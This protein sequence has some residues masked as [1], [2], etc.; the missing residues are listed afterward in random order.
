MGAMEL[1]IF[2]S[3]LVVLGAAFV[4]LICDFLK[5]NNEKLREFNIE[6]ITRQEERERA[7][8]SA[9][10]SRRSGQPQAAR[11][12]EAGGFAEGAS[13]PASQVVSHAS[14]VAEGIPAN[15]RRRRAGRGADPV[16]AGSAPAGLATAAMPPPAPVTA[17]VAMEDW[18][19]R[20]VEHGASRKMEPALGPEFRT[21]AVEPV[22]VESASPVSQAGPRAAA[23]SESVLPVSA[24]L[25][26]IG[27]PNPIPVA[28]PASE[29]DINFVDADSG[30]GALLPDASVAAESSLPF[31][32]LQPLELAPLAEGT[33]PLG[34]EATFVA[35]ARDA[36]IGEPAG[37]VDQR[38]KD[39]SLP[40]AGLSELEMPIPSAVKL[41][42]GSMAPGNVNPEV[43]AASIEFQTVSQPGSAPLEPAL[44]V[45]GLSDLVI[46]S[47]AAVKS[48][49]GEVAPVVELEI[50]SAA[51]FAG[52]RYGQ[53]PGDELAPMEAA[54]QPISALLKPADSSRAQLIPA[55]SHLTPESG[56][57]SSSDSG[58]HRV[59][60]EE[61][62]P[63]AGNTE[64]SVAL[65]PLAKR[66]MALDATPEMGPVMMDPDAGP[67]GLKPQTGGSPRLAAMQLVPETTFAA[68]LV[69]AGREPDV[70]PVLPEIQDPAYNLASGSMPQPPDW[71]IEEE[72]PE[73]A[74]PNPEE[75]VR[76]RV[77]DESDLFQLCGLIQL[78]VSPVSPAAA[79]GLL[80][81]AGLPEWSC[82][83]DRD[84]EIVGS[85][86]MN[87]AVAEGS[88]PAVGVV[89]EPAPAAC[90][91]ARSR[92]RIPEPRV[93]ESAGISLPCFYPYV[94]ADL[95]IEA[96][97]CADTMPMEFTLDS[98]LEDAY[99]PP[100]PPLG[101]DIEPVEDG[102]Y[103]YI[104][105]DNEPEM[106]P[107]V[108]QMP[109]PVQAA[110]EPPARVALRIPR[111][112]HDRAAFD[113]LAS[114]PANF[115]GV[116]FLVG[117][118][119]F[120]HLVADHGQP[121]VAQAI[122]EATSYFGGLLKTDGFGCW[123]EDS[124]FVMI[125]PAA[126]AEQARQVMTHTAEGLW[127]YQLRSLGSLPLIFHWGSSEASGES[128]GAAVERARDQM[129]ESGR[130]RKKVLTT[131]GRF[132]RRVVNG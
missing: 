116:V 76:V 79:G 59:H 120:D 99:V 104:E 90:A 119:G 11:V 101:Y 14:T 39:P 46:S 27:S 35:V 28:V 74:E 8:A 117:V 29:I 50:A 98:D 6:L 25:V 13:R 33:A 21:A 95:E 62:L 70:L 12:V 10:Q 30:Q 112:V 44:P 26:S 23:S 18:A 96:T 48:Q 80:V 45:A 32:E 130:T 15:P 7:T 85:T 37:Q 100:A 54:L 53:A 43:A 68:G 52:L 42:A 55:H 49:A 78:P 57:T 36:G 123:I 131:S 118:M 86:S 91:M 3:L 9:A 63:L 110:F 115:D 16:Q 31:G 94:Q 75:V 2:V 97:A 1:Q 111:G 38:A 51:G 107:K 83:L 24:D 113:H 93:L 126:S 60:A 67:T 106:N 17:I 132:R 66:V 72:T 73:I 92:V 127:D 69:S 58:V 105:V 103:H 65:P 89:P 129:I 22:I 4:A 77:L 40:M 34:L 88:L 114:Q 81:A 109:L 84:P 19:K 108:V 122:G 64:I 87:H 56:S 71:T 125:L 124:A 41:Q 128:L 82:R 61:S 5:G 47:A 102:G 121:A 20:V